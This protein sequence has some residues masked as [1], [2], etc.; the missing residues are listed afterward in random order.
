MLIVNKFQEMFN[1][2]IYF[3]HSLGQQREG[4]DKTPEIIDKFLNNKITK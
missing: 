1:N 4:V 2:I 3:P